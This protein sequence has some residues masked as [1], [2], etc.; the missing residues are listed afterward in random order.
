[1]PGES[2]ADAPVDADKSAPGYGAAKTAIH[3][4]TALCDQLGVDDI[5]L[6]LTVTIADEG[7]NPHD[8]KPKLWGAMAAKIIARH[9]PSGRSLLMA[10]EQIEDLVP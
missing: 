7:K 8:G 1:M 9:Q 3:R 10:T 4:F 2:G 5:D 6:K